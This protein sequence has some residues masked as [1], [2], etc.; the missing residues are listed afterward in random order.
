M[1]GKLPQIISAL[2][3]RRLAFRLDL[4]PLE[5]EGLPWSKVTNWLLTESSVIFKPSK[6]WGLPTILQIEPTSRCNLECRICPVATGLQRPAGNMDLSLFRRIV[7]ELRGSLLAILFWD[8]GEPFLNPHAYD[9][10][11]YARQAG[12]KVVSS[13]NGHVFADPAQAR[14]VVGSGLEVLVFSVDGISQGTY[15]HIRQKGRLD[16]VL[17][18]IQL[19]VAEK[20]RAGRRLPVVNLRFVVTQHSEQE[21]PLLA[22]F[23]RGLGVDVLTLR[24]LHYV[25]ETEAQAPTGSGLIPTERKFQ[26][27]PLAQDTGMPLRE[28]RNPCRNLWNCPTVHWDGTVC[29]CFM[30]YNERR[31]LGSLR[32]HG[33]RDIWRGAAYRSL[34]AEFRRRWREL[35]LCGECAS[36]FE[37]GDVGREAN[38]EV[39][40]FPQGG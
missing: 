4:V 38:A 5:F 15:Q 13:T 24:K 1:I 21:V 16:T 20:R 18:G 26:L 9:M 22:E 29:S 35:P 37:G 28:A 34:R 33:F 6:P 14:E 8:W 27:P 23:A 36:G 2:T 12:V 30:D 3:S 17:E 10:I 11:R 32:Q 7:D 25:P 31:P 39:V 19:V 40:F